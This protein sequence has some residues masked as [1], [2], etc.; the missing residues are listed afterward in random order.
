MTLPTENPY[1]WWRVGVF[2]G[3]GKGTAKKPQGYPWQSLWIALE[4]GR[5]RIWIM[6][7]HYLRH[8]LEK[9]SEQ[10]GLENN[11]LTI[12]CQSSHD[13]EELNNKN[14]GDELSS[15][16]GQYFRIFARFGSRVTL[17]VTL[18]SS[19]W[20]Y[21][22]GEVILLFTFISFLSHLLF[23]FLLVFFAFR[24]TVARVTA[25]VTAE[26]SAEAISTFAALS[27]IT[28]FCYFLVLFRFIIFGFLWVLFLF[29]REA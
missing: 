8:L 18:L 17:A 22:S 20:H 4:G 2:W 27:E 21:C 24:H 26:V 3:R 6:R 23:C 10:K 25:D 29:S 9:S 19:R 28:L 16:L 7:C 14:C 11:G 13:L 1:P 5:D 15:S 12:D